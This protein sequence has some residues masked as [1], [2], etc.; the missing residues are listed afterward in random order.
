LSIVCVEGQG[1]ADKVKLA[2]GLAVF[3]CDA[4]LENCEP[5]IVGGDG[6]YLVKSGSSE[7]KICWERDIDCTIQVN[8]E[9]SGLYL[10]ALLAKEPWEAFI[11]EH[12]IDPR[13]L[14]GMI[15]CLLKNGFSLEKA[16]S[17]TMEVLT[18]DSNPFNYLKR[19]LEE[20]RA[21]NRLLDAADRLLKNADLARKLAENTLVM[22][23]KPS[24]N[25]VY[26]IR[27]YTEPRT[28]FAGPVERIDTRIRGEY[29]AVEAGTGFLCSDK[30]LNYLFEN[31]ERAGYKLVSVGSMSCVVSSDV[32]RIVI[33]LEK[34]A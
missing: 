25:I 23:V 2:V 20:H 33:L 10:H 4:V 26:A 32:M 11:T 34:K 16:F 14:A 1:F 6:V 21:L 5:A 27:F 13:I 31:V 22:G 7:V 18:A 19:V 24:D 30:P 9:R 17:K 29:G 15:A 28:V 12:R 8:V 3:G